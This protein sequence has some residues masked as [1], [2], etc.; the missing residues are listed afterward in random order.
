M[1]QLVGAHHDTAR[2]EGG[3]RLGRPPAKLFL[4]QAI[5]GVA[6]ADAEGAGDV[7]LVEA[8]A[9]DVADDVDELVD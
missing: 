8:F 1:I 5:V 7:A 6:P 9:G 3:E 2:A 4:D